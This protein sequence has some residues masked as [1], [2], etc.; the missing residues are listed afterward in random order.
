MRLPLTVVL[1]GASLIV[2]SRLGGSSATA[3]EPTPA[4]PSENL[5][6]LCDADAT[7]QPPEPEIIAACFEASRPSLSVKHPEGQESSAYL[8]E[9]P[10]LF[11]HDPVPLPEPAPAVSRLSAA[12]AGA[13]SDAPALQVS[14]IAPP[15][16]V[17]DNHDVRRF[18]DQFQTGYR[19]A[20]VERWL[21]RAG[22]YLPMVLNVFK[23]KGLPEELVF[24]AM[25]ESG[26]DPL[27]AS[28]AGAKGIWQ[29]MA[30]TARRYGLRVDNWLDERLDPEKSTVA[31][32]RHFVDLYA[33][34]GSW[35]LAQAAYN[36]GERTVLEAIKAMGTS[37]FWTLARGRW[38][39]DE[40]KNFIP[41]IQAATL[42]AREPERYGFMV[43]P[44][45]P[46]MYDL[47]SVPGSTSLRLLASK[48]GLDPD[49][50]ERLNPELRLKQ[51]PPGGTY[52]LK[53]PVGGAVLVRAA[54]DRDVSGRGSAI[55]AAHGARGD[56]VTSPS[57]AHP[58]RPAIHVVKRQETIA[59]IAKRYR[60]PVSDLIRWNGLGETPRIRAG[61]RLRVASA[62]RG[63][64]AQGSLK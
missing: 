64:E 48:S 12:Q 17:E 61:D 35:N 53:V 44:A 55:A 49:S 52:S 16:R 7:P 33:V 50:L 2:A 18:L 57:A 1:F 24:T 38:L 63:E 15:Y 31:A 27:A 10:A 5:P 42:I 41:A 32:A 56:Y 13:P 21:V 51:T 59:A 46:L 8:A 3:T 45:A 54:L 43:T 4:S 58:T 47:V 11:V 26:F 40:T 22:R 37:D 39:R 6:I 14:L 19:R 25:I 60:V 20:I 62:G 28:R 34:F 29:F 23:Q 30:P 36:A 9:D